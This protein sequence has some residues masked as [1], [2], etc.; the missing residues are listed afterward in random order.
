V[1]RDAVLA[2]GAVPD[3]FPGVEIDGHLHWDGLFSQNP[4]LTDLL[5][6]SP[7][8]K[9][10]EIW[11]VQI[12]PQERRETPRTLVEIADRRNELAGNISLNQQLRSV[13][14]NNEWIEEGYLP[15][16]TFSTVGF[17]RIEIGRQY[18]HATK[19]DRR[20]EFVEEL[21]ELGREQG[22]EFCRRL[23]ETEPDY[24]PSENDAH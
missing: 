8:R 19:L 24:F 21:L 9:P 12:N 18:D 5:H 17:R 11:I 2:S 13:K 23:A 7:E 1:S 10:D 14:R 16:E 6:A 4:P 22:E 3:L 20:L 15:S